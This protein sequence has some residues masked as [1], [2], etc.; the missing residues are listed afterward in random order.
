MTDNHSAPSYPT[1]LLGLVLGFGLSTT[2][3]LGALIWAAIAR[4]QSQAM[5]ALVVLAVSV[6]GLA[7][8]TRIILI[9]QRR[10]ERCD[11]R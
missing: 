8:M 11:E 6:A 10:F 2:F 5:A 3:S 7:L 9:Y 1:A 4:H